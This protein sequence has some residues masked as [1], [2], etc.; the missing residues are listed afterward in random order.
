MSR[1]LGLTW[2]DAG[3][4]PWWQYRAAV[5]GLVQEFADPDRRQAAQPEPG[6]SP[7][8]TARRAVT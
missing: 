5:D 8:R 1:H 2:N 3:D 7:I 6:G 4:L